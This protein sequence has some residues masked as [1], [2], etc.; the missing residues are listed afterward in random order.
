[1]VT[2][3]LMVC[4]GNICRSPLAEGI[5]KSKVNSKTVYV[6][7]AGTAGYHIG[8]KPDTRSIAIANNY[9]IDINDQRCRKFETQDFDEFDTIYVMDK[10]NYT[11]VI[12]KSRNSIDE[13]K[14]QTHIR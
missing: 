7:S 12:S 3:V 13:A 1:M 14:V 5:L 2:K 4:L 8:N 9:G 10:S 11:N 6:D